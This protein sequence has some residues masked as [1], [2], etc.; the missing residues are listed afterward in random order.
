[1]VITI[2]YVLMILNCNQYKYKADF[3]KKTW[4]TKLPT[5]IIYFH[6][7]GRPDLIDE[8]Q[9]DISNNLLYV[10]NEDDYISLPSKTINAINAIHAN[11]DYKYILKT[12]DD[13]M[14]IDSNFFN[15]LFNTLNINQAHYGGY[16]IKCK[17]HISIYNMIH[18]EL[19]ADILLKACA[20]SS[21][22][23]YFLSKEVV[24]FLLLKK[25]LIYTHFFEDHAIGYHLSNFPLLKILS[26]DTSKSFIDI[27]QY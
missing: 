21:G 14:L 8:Y 9:F 13:Q 7:I 16:I 19:P 5:N 23:F 17:E 27:L 3:Q 15:N 4:L 11:Y 12:D 22:R 2:D 18:T 25:Q 6:V 24:P 10:R 26:F 20:Y 1:M